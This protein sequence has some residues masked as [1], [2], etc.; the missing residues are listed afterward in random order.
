MNR[1]SLPPMDAPLAER[2]WQSRRAAPTPEGLT[3]T[4]AE[5]LCI[6]RGETPTSV[7]R[8]RE[9]LMLVRQGDLGSIVQ[10]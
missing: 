5:R 9:I 8:E 1:E 10:H 3:A 6:Q 4:G 7:R 2:R